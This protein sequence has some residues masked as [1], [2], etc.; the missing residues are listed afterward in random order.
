VKTKV[1]CIE[2]VGDAVNSGARKHKAC[3]V[4]GIPTR[5]LE[6]WEKK[7][8]KKDMRKGPN[9]MPA[10]K[11]SQ[12]E[13]DAILEECKSKE[14]QD[15][16]P[17]QIVPRLADKG[18][19]L[20]SEATFYRVLKEAKMLT[21][22]SDTKPKNRH[23]PDEHIATAPNQVWSWDVT[24]LKTFTKGIFFYLNF[25]L[26]IYSRKIVGWDV[27]HEDNAENASVL[28][29]ITCM[30]ECIAS[31]QIVLH[32]DNGKSQ[33]GAT[34]LGMLEKLGVA[35]SFSRPSVSNDNPYSEAL[36]KT[37][38]Y[39]PAYPEK[40]FANIEEAKI[41]VDEF[42]TWYN[43]VHLHSGIKFVTPESRHLELDRAILENRKNVYE[44]AKALHPNRW[45]GNTRNWN[46]IEEVSLNPLTT[47]KATHTLNGII[48]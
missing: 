48:N 4:L 9:T 30:I 37:T 38:K 39:M 24:Y 36:F 28:A 1:L 44:R 11:Y 21:H 27:Y 8:E 32:S 26:D 25:I 14:F 17:T 34:T 43:T 42:V 41:W 47:S 12:K 13:K 40:G 45:S 35:T 23:K 16:P 5:T 46:Y 22:R 10:N 2:L 6:R 18:I 29:E 3:D 33:K 19:Y 31:G 15:L 20:G 7:Q